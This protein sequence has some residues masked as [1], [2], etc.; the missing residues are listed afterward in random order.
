VLAQQKLC[1]HLKQNH[2]WGCDPISQSQ[3]FQIQY[4]YANIIL[5]VKVFLGLPLRKQH[6]CLTDKVDYIFHFLYLAMKWPQFLP[7]L[8]SSIPHALLEV[9]GIREPLVWQ[10]PSGL[11]TVEANTYLRI[12]KWCVLEKNFPQRVHGN[13]SLWDVSTSLPETWIPHEQVAH[14]R[15]QKFLEHLPQTFRRLFLVFRAFFFSNL[16]VA[17]KFENSTP[18]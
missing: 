14:F 4:K 5:I 2:R 8:F 11:E 17:V 13:A 1:Q 15:D 9:C 12:E 7:A 3:S 16:W 18:H 6:I 10:W